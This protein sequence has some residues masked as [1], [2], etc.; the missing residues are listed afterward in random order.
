MRSGSPHNYLRMVEHI[1]ALKLGLGVDNVLLKVNSG[2]PPLFDASSLPL[3]KAMEHA[4]I[5]ETEEDATF[6]TV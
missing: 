3:I 2:D 5:V 1:V 6:V 4:K